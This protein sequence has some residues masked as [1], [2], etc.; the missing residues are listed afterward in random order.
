[1]LNFQADRAV[2]G[3]WNRTEQK[4]DEL[5]AAFLKLKD[6]V[7]G[8]LKIESFFVSTKILGG[9]ERLGA[10]ALFGG[11]SMSSSRAIRYAQKA[12]SGRHEC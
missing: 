4:V 1:V 9:V 7:D 3:I 2:Q 10:S 12:Q 11:G 5:S 8:R 6:S